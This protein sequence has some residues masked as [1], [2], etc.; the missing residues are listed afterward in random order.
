MAESGVTT[1][2]QKDA[3][4]DMINKMKNPRKKPDSMSFT[5]GWDVVA[6]YSE[7]QIN[8]LLADRHSR[9]KALLREI[10]FSS[11]DYDARTDETYT[12]KYVV[13]F[14]PPLL[15]FDP[16]STSVPSCSIKMAILSGTVQFSEQGKIKQ[17]APGWSIELNNIPL[18]TAAGKIT[19][20]GIINPDH[21]D[22]IAGTKPVHFDFEEEK[23]QHVVLGFH[24]DKDK[25]VVNPVP[26]AD[27]DPNN[28]SHVALNNSFKNAFLQYFVGSATNGE[29]PRCFSYSIASVN[30][31]ASEMGVELRPEKFQFATYFGEGQ[32]KNARLLSIFIQ[33]HGGKGKGNTVKLQ[34][35]WTTQWFDNE[36]SPVPN[37]FSASLII[38]ASLFTDV[39]LARGFRDSNWEVR[40]ITPP[41]EAVAKLECR[42]NEQWTLAAQDHP[43]GDTSIFHVDGFTANLHDSPMTLTIQQ[44]DAGT[45]PKVYAH[46]PIERTIAWNAT[47]K[48]LGVFGRSHLDS[49]SIKAL[50]RLCDEHDFNRPRQLNSEIK[51]GDDDSLQLDLKLQTN[52]FRMDQGEK[53]AIHYDTWIKGMR[54]LWTK[55]P[56]AGVSSFSFGFLRTTNLLMPGQHVIDMNKEIG[57]RLPKD[58]VL[59][60]DVAKL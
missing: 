24:M 57:P 23:T 41:E 33:V 60:G 22:L 39:I 46:W 32:F 13:N 10:A 11:Q 19:E 1:Q 55:A 35:R 47:F 58:L 48:P 17:I 40:D 44:E 25:V 21:L 42:N 51:I 36:A 53:N 50:F 37:G 5:M 28:L 16:K 31:Q 49:G 20:E 9:T 34:E 12:T 15:Q 6:N 54:G 27:W 30:N 8:K 59:V 2:A 45:G 7:E 43:Y 26:P 56:V 18:A 52:T 38:S 29:L 4:K 3:V 14:G